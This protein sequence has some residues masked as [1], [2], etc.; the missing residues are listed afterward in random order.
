MNILISFA[1]DQ[2]KSSQN[3]LEIQSYKMGADKVISYKNSDID[4]TFIRENYKILQSPRGAG[5]W[6]WK[7][8]VI[9]KTLENC[10]D[11][12]K[13]L[14]SDSGAYPIEDLNYLYSITDKQDIVLFRLF[15]KFNRDW[16]KKDCF[17]LMNCKEEKYY[18]TDQTLATFQ[19]YKNNEK[20]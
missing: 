17:N 18:N 2:F 9:L 13:I 16:T 20:D 12:D 7:P 14:Y 11:G 6:L 8:Y 19:L 10:N 3:V 4:K 1:T 5:Y 15:D